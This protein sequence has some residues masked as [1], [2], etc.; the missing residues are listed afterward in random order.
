MKHLRQICAGLILVLALSLP[1]FA[2]DIPS[3]PGAPGDISTP[4]VAG[5]TQFPG[6]TGQQESPGVAGDVQFPGI[7]GEIGMPGLLFALFFFF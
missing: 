1:V 5:E 3:P 2:G 6:V 4:G 7:T